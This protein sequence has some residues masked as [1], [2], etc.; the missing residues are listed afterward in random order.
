MIVDL[1]M[2]KKF[3]AMHKSRGI[4]LLR[5]KLSHDELLRI[6]IAL[7]CRKNEILK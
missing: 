1:A 5:A 3:D 4:Q 7:E 6:V 2:F